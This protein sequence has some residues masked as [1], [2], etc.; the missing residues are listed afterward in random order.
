MPNQ[1]IT[2]RPAAIILCG[3]RSTRM[4]RDK[5]AIRLGN[6]TL[7][8]R[9]CRLTSQVAT[10]IVVV[11]A[12]HQEF[13]SLPESVV[14]ARDHYPGEGPL[15]GLLTGLS[16]LQSTYPEMWTHLT[17]WASTCDAPFV[18]GTVIQHLHDRLLKNSHVDAVAVEHEGMR[19][20]FATVYRSSVL[21]KARS[22]FDAG[23]RRAVALL[24][25]IN[26]DFV[27][28]T[29]LSAIDPALRCLMNVNTPEDFTAAERLID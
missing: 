9:V 28:G 1:Q 19:N 24:S 4:G 12:P 25:A 17:I 26:V 2:N 5:A 21:N 23:E 16:H 8:H 15:G 18:N 10:P 27:P 20:P 22:L 3:G 13:R 7:L 11:A 14:V 6:E 29:D